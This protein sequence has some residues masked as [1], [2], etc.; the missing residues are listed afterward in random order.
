M[1]NVLDIT[2]YYEFSKKMQDYKEA[3]EL[4]K[5]FYESK[6]LDLMALQKAV[7]IELQKIHVEKQK[8][9]KHLCLMGTSKYIVI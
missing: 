6:M 1:L 2:N 9:S 4:K 3:I 8:K 5:F 7:N